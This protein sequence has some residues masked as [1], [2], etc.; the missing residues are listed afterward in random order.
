MEDG[1]G[2]RRRMVKRGGE[3]ERGGGGGGGGK[4]ERG[5]CCSMLTTTLSFLSPRASYET[6]TRSEE[7]KEVRGNASER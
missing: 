4:R 1:R 2:D 7:M 5:L 6:N 3:G